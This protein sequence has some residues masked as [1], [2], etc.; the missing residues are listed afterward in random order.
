MLGGIAEDPRLHCLAARVILN[1]V[2]YFGGK[3]IG[4]ICHSHQFMNVVFQPLCT[5]GGRYA[6]S[7]MTESFNELDLQA[8]AHDQRN[9]A[10]GRL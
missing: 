1:E 5:D 9:Q 6:S 4:I 3:G 2:D 8:S 10:Q 7:S